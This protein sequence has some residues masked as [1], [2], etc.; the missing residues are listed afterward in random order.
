[1]PIII[2]PVNA[3]QLSKKF[4][5]QTIG[6]LFSHILSRLFMCLE[7]PADTTQEQKVRLQVI[8]EKLRT[9]V[10]N[11]NRYDTDQNVAATPRI[12]VL[13]ITILQRSIAGPATDTVVAQ[14]DLTQEGLADIYPAQ[15]LTFLSI[16]IKECMSSMKSRYPM[17]PRLMAV[18]NE[19]NE[20]IERLIREI[21]PILEAPPE[22]ANGLNAVDPFTNV[23]LR[24]KV[25]HEL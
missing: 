21:A 24:L 5:P 12:T 18:L 3:D 22:W 20:R 8:Q 6:I 9:Y 14:F 1:M 13:C 17:T 16:L 11:L 2:V 23:L 4:N 25:G 15:V 19:Y 7:L 10:F